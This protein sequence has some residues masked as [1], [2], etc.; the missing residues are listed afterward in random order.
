MSVPNSSRPSWTSRWFVIR[1][2]LIVPLVHG[3][4]KVFG[5]RRTV[6]RLKWLSPTRVDMTI[7]SIDAE[8][9]GRQMRGLMRHVR[10]R[11]PMPGTCLSRS[12]ALWWKLDRQGVATTVNIGVLRNRLVFPAH[13]WVEYQGVPLNARRDVRQSYQTFDDLDHARTFG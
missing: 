10:D 8:S 2:S 11:S 7:E 9:Y 4:L 1:L 13:A 3:H 5:Y 12:L 6:A